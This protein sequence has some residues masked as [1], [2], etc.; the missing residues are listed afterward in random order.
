MTIYHSDLHKRKRSGGRKSPYRGRRRYEFGSPNTRTVVGDE[1]TL[2]TRSMGGNFKVRSLKVKYVNLSDRSGKVV[3][4]EVLSVAENPAGVD[5][6]RGGII[7]KGTIIQT[8]LGRA[9]VTSRPGQ[10]GSISAVIIG[11]A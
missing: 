11:E 4:S 3:K 2:R 1:S 5:L 7:T 9:R 6:R 8:P 10:V